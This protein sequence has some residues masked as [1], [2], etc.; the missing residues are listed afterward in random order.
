MNN[1]ELFSDENSNKLVQK[2]DNLTIN[3]GEDNQ[4]VLNIDSS[5]YVNN[6][7]RQIPDEFK[8]TDKNKYLIVN[9]KNNYKYVDLNLDNSKFRFHKI[10]SEKGDYDASSGVVTPTDGDIHLKMN[11]TMVIFLNFSAYRSSALVTWTFKYRIKGTGTY[12]EFDYPEQGQFKHYYSASGDHQHRSGQIVFNSSSQDIIIDSFDVDFTNANIDGN[13]FLSMNALIIQNNY[14]KSV[15]VPDKYNSLINK[16]VINS[17]ILNYTD[18][19]I[20]FP[21]FDSGIRYVSSYQDQ[22]KL[23]LSYPFKKGI[24]GNDGQTNYGSINNSDMTIDFTY[25]SFS[26]NQGFTIRN[27]QTPINNISFRKTSGNFNNSGDDFTLYLRW[28]KTGSVP[29]EN[30]SRLIS[31]WQNTSNSTRLQVNIEENV[32][33]VIGEPNNNLI[34]WFGDTGTTSVSIL[35]TVTLDRW[36]NLIVVL[37]NTNSEA[38]VYMDN[39][40]QGI[41]EYI[42]SIDRSSVSTYV[43]NN[44]SL[45]RNRYDNSSNEFDGDFS[46]FYLFND[47]LTIQQS[48]DWVNYVLNNYNFN[49]DVYND[50]TINRGYLDVNVD[51]S[52]HTHLLPLIGLDFDHAANGGGNSDTNNI[53]LQDKF[54][55]IP[56]VSTSIYDKTIY[57]KFKQDATTSG[58]ARSLIIELGSTHRIQLVQRINETRWTVEVNNGTTTYSQQITTLTN[59]GTGYFI[60]FFITITSTNGWIIRFGPNSILTELAS[61]SNIPNLNNISN[62]RIGNY[63]DGSI[64]RDLDGQVSAFVLFNQALSL[65]ESQ[66]WANYIDTTKREI[67]FYAGSELITNDGSQIWNKPTTNNL[68]GIDN[69]SAYNAVT[70]NKDNTALTCMSNNEVI[71]LPSGSTRQRPN[72]TKNGQIR[73]NTTTS[74]YEIYKDNSWKKIITSDISINNQINT[75]V[76][77]S[78]YYNQLPAPYS[79]SICL[80]HRDFSGDSRYDDHSPY[81]SYGA[82]VNVQQKEYAPDYSELFGRNVWYENSFDIIIYDTSPEQNMAYVRRYQPGEQPRDTATNSDTWNG[83]GIVIRKSGTYIL[84]YSSSIRHTDGT[85]YTAFYKNNTNISQQTGTT[86]KTINGIGHNFINKNYTTYLQEGDLIRIRSYHTRNS[87][88]TWS[89]DNMTAYDYNDPTNAYNYDYMLKIASK[90]T[91]RLLDSTS[92]GSGGG[93]GGGGY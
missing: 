86:T 3:L 40:T 47:K 18:T 91:V 72:I 27:D 28:R 24:D 52:S 93:G 39:T 49:I 43:F 62:I 71:Q 1:T 77:D 88:T 4:D 78:S 85:F 8:T 56:N 12:L 83:G 2:L 45:G 25:N 50:Y 19:L 5:V 29:G 82:Y 51:F 87:H 35:G 26:Q 61:D 30:Y 57:I 70:I 66:E 73:Y 64:N 74:C 38:K 21:F 63:Y 79:A 46:D 33:N 89:K 15:I 65:Y 6:I 42:G 69:D 23:L 11:E 67:R 59:N 16:D 75:E 84:Y 17:D 32:D 36:Y 68:I 55:I 41:L 13:D 90:L 20:A 22:T 80:L 58:N 53:R 37:D 76:S 9:T 60:H 10:C 54:D 31:A 7:E 44:I 92:L 14:L 48:Q 81:T 34:L